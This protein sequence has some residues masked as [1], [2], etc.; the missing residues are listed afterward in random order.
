MQPLLEAQLTPPGSARNSIF[1]GLQPTCA[2]VPHSKYPTIR[3][4]P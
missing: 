2:R 4:L 3:S 1:S